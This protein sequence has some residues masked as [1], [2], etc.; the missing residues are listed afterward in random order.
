MTRVPSSHVSHM[1]SPF[2]KKRYNPDWKES[3]RNIVLGPSPEAMAYKGDD[4]EPIPR[5]PDYMVIDDERGER[6]KMEVIHYGHMKTLLRELGVKDIETIILSYF[7]KELGDNSLTLNSSVFPTPTNEDQVAVNKIATRVCMNDTW[8][9]IREVYPCLDEFIYHVG[10]AD[11]AYMV[12][13][14]Y[15]DLQTDILHGVEK[16]QDFITFIMDFIVSTCMPCV[17]KNS[18]GCRVTEKKLEEALKKCRGTR[19]KESRKKLLRFFIHHINNHKDGRDVFPMNPDSATNLVPFAGAGI[20]SIP[21]QPIFAYG[22]TPTPSLNMYGGLGDRAVERAQSVFPVTDVRLSSQTEH[23][24]PESLRGALRQLRN[25]RKINNDEISLVEAIGVVTNILRDRGITISIG[26][27]QDRLVYKGA[28][29]ENGNNI[30]ESEDERRETEEMLLQMVGEAMEE[31]ISFASQII[32]SDQMHE[33][34]LSVTAEGE[35]DEN[36][37]WRTKY[38]IIVTSGKMRSVSLSNIKALQDQESGHNAIV[39][40]SDDVEIEAN[41]DN[42][43]RRVGD[44]VTPESEAFQLFTENL[45]HP[46]HI[47]NLTGDPSGENM[48]PS[49]FAS[50]WRKVMRIGETNSKDLSKRV[51]I[52]VVTHDS[53]SKIPGGVDK[54]SFMLADAVDKSDELRKVKANSDIEKLLEMAKIE[55]QKFEEFQSKFERSGL[56]KSESKAKAIESVG[57]DGID[58]IARDLHI[59]IQSHFGDVAPPALDEYA[60]ENVSRYNY[61]MEKRDAGKGKDNLSISEQEELLDFQRGVDFA[62]IFIA[63]GGAGLSWIQKLGRLQQRGELNNLPFSFRNMYNL[64]YDVLE[65]VDDSAEKQTIEKNVMALLCGKHI[66]NING[67]TLRNIRD[68]ANDLVF[69]IDAALP[70]K[71][72]HQMAK[73]QEISILK[74]VGYWLFSYII[75]LLAAEKY[76]KRKIP[77]R[78]KKL[79]RMLKHGLIG[80][81]G[82][83][84]M[85]PGLFL[86]IL[87]LAALNFHV[88]FDGFAWAVG[89]LFVK[90]GIWEEENKRIG[91]KDGNIREQI[92]NEVNAAA[93]SEFTPA[94]LRRI[95]RAQNKAREH[96]IVS[97]GGE[98]AKGTMRR[99]LNKLSDGDDRK[100]TLRRRRGL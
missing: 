16:I 62:K 1:R 6:E 44:S 76:K 99:E 27:E 60:M 32:L 3:F 68:R 15:V 24:E 81:V 78:K 92:R 96:E 19:C 34:P 64:Y 23:V 5:I 51:G 28:T 46:N 52:F 80:F 25:I 50:S 94:E 66:S 67:L 35:F 90:V 93:T 8:E 49:V 41:I 45:L 33:T 56:S 21:T 48:S 97:I 57:S 87:G 59:A 43:V 79:I 71:L 55:Q 86:H 53:I 11:V 69:A 95:E 17:K 29:D 30:H 61:L 54:L 75:L 47:F 40:A 88:L 89:E 31:D 98:K 58:I 36:G 12:G 83:N 70:R 85:A 10:D 65:T 37:K 26:I 84:A 63:D 91:R 74:D 100:K 13:Y 72:G 38:I 4:P 20:N 22:V 9:S 82:F 39:F 14:P 42:V 18:G 7:K 2:R 73:P 77:E